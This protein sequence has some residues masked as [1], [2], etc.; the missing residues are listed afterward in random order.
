MAFS[1]TFNL[2]H[3]SFDKTTL[4]IF[5]RSV[6]VF[7]SVMLVFVTSKIYKH[8]FGTTTPRVLLIFLLVF[9]WF[10]IVYAHYVNADIVLAFLLSLSFLFFAQYYWR[11]ND[12]KFTVLAALFFGLAIG[13]KITAL[14]SMP[15]FLYIF[16]KKKDAMGLFGF[17]AVAFVAFSVSNP[18]SII[19]L[20]DFTFRIYAML[21]KEG[22]M[23]FD[24]VNYSLL[25]YI[26]SLSKILTVPVFLLA[27]FGMAKS[28]RDILSRFFIFNVVLYFIFY[29]IQ[30]RLIDRWLLPII[31]ILIMYASYAIYELRTKVSKRL[32]YIFIASLCL[33]YLYKPVLLLFQFKRYTPKSET[34]LWMKEQVGFYDTT[35]V[36][37][38]EGLD[39]MNKLPGAKVLVAAVYASDGAQFQRP[40]D[41]RYYNYVVLSSKPMAYHKNPVVTA[42]YPFYTKAW[43]DF[44]STVKSSDFELI[45]S[46]ALTN[47]E[48]IN[49]SNVYVYK[50]LH[51]IRP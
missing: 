26:G 8:V 6:M 45:K 22:G 34:Y 33:A 15:A 37:T 20:R 21:F 51:I 13:T 50:N 17:I 42:K 46:F 1:K 16:V 5:M 12:T 19:F 43:A 7:F 29:S 28:R 30:S 4:Y 35:L 3:I 31:P 44:E 10:F 36:I 41:P 25:K 24:S 48:L 14:I 11:Q 18:F 40:L 27:I 2:V 23:V 32:F 9:N 38:E 39:P 47:P 49:V